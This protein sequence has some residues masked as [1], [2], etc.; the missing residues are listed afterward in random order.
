MTTKIGTSAQSFQLGFDTGSADLWVYGSSLDSSTDE[1]VFTT[2][3]SST[4]STENTAW[5]ISYGK[6]SETGVV[7]T[8]IVTVAGYSVQ[9]QTFA[10]AD[11]ISSAFADQPLS[12]LF[13]FAFGAL[14][15]TGSTPFFES[16]MAQGTLTG[17]QQYFSVFLN[18][19]PLST[20]SGATVSGG[21]LCL[22][23][24]DSSKY[25]G[26]IVYTPV[27]SEAYWTI[28]ADCLS[29]HGASVASTS[30]YAAL[31]SG[32]SIITL[33]TTTAKALYKS[34]GATAASSND[35]YYVSLAATCR[36]TCERRRLTRALPLFRS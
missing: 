32:S 28:A 33:P 35:G 36:Q 27:V 12:G 11:S 24:L 17:S 31:D 16:L 22:G 18:R 1:T 10:V 34:L 15:G 5:S 20:T 21:E 13:G 2:S 4:Y 29:N 8:D 25:T 9:D 7:G 6:G 3:K 30:F 19:A 14:S 23:C 26:S